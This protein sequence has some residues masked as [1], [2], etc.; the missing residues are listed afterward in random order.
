MLKMDEVLNKRMHEVHLFL[1]HKIDKQKLESN[2]RKG[3][4]VTEL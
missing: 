2:L 3:T 1:A 4:N